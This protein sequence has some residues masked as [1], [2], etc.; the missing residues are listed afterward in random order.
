[1]KWYTAV[2][3]IKSPGQVRKFLDGTWERDMAV[4]T[5]H[6]Q[7]FAKSQDDADRHLGRIIINDCK[8]HG[9]SLVD[10]RSDISQYGPVEFRLPAQLHRKIYG[11]QHN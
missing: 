1:M 5:I 7:V 9:W 3:R 11:T 2:V 6:R 10:W 8:N 4:R